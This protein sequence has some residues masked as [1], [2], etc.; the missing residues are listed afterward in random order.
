[1]VF[2]HTIL[3]KLNVDFNFFLQNST[4]NEVYM[5]KK[6][7]NASDYFQTVTIERTPEMMV[8]KNIEMVSTSISKAEKKPS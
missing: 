1:M 5:A 3:E 6:V 7:S 4:E 8:T 2:E